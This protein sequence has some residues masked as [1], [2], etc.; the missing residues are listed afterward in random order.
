MEAGSVSVS[1][2]NALILG[3]AGVGKTSTKCIL[4]NEDPP[5][6]RTSTPLAEA[7]IQIRLDNPSPQTGLSYSGQRDVEVVGVK[8][9]AGDSSWKSLDNKRL[10]IV[11][12][13]AI[14]ALIQN[15]HR[16]TENQSQD[17]SLVFTYQGSTR[18]NQPN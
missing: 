12:A 13:D 15:E 4:F 10:E 8:V 5:Q 2:I 1:M 18:T 9:Q 14:A 11:V 17:V 6:V 7:P 3:E 16:D